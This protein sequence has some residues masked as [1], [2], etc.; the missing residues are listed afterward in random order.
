MYGQKMGL[1]VEN[2]QD[3]RQLLTP[4]Y[5][6]HFLLGV[7]SRIIFAEYWKMIQKRP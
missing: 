5:M 6:Y 7:E 3:E 2:K 1:L 4:G